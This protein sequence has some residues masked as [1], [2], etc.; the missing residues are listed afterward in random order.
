MKYYFR[1]ILY[2]VSKKAPRNFI[3]TFRAISQLFIFSFGKTSWIS[4]FLL[5]LWENE[6][7]FFFTNSESLLEI[8]HS[9]IF[10]NSLFTLRKISIYIL[11][12]VEK[13]CAVNK[14]NRFRNIWRELKTVEKREVLKWIPVEQRKFYG[15][16]IF[17]WTFFIQLCLK[18]IF[19]GESF[20]RNSSI[21]QVVTWNYKSLIAKMFD[22][23]KWQMKTAS[24]T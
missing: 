3:D 11:G 5:G 16:S 2:V 14:H 21:I 22:G 1:C 15:F 10:S 20:F 17:F 8:N 12:W 13:I 7:L 23:N 18:N 6:Y 4:S 24:P 9:L 19:W